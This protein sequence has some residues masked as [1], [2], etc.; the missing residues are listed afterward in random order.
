MV[1]FIFY[2]GDGSFTFGGAFTELA[3]AQNAFDWFV[4][5]ES[6]SYVQ[7]LSSTATT[8]SESGTHP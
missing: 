5:L 6:V 4:S 1:Y 2:Y 3:D 7:L 8:V